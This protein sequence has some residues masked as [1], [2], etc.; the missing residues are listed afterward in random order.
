MVSLRLS[1][2]G[3]KDRPYYK[4]V[5]VDSRKRRDGRYIEQIGTY[6]PMVEGENY[7]LDLEKADKWLGVGAKAST[8]VASIIKKVR[9]AD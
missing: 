8:T 7:A 5:A 4:I 3:S 1:R 6:D 2:K 9:N